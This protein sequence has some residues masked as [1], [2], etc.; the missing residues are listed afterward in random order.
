LGTLR[1]LRP[2]RL[3]LSAALED[4]RPAATRAT[5][6]RRAELRADIRAFMARR[7]VLEV[8][9]PLIGSAAP[10]E[11]GCGRGRTGRAAVYAELLRL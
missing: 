4:W 9:T 6:A 7:G 2:F 5:L 8:D 3:Q 11:R 10:A 1:G